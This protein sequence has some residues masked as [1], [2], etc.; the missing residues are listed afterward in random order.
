MCEGKK[1]G[2]RYVAAVYVDTNSST[3]GR[4]EGKRSNDLLAKQTGDKKM[5]SPV[6]AVGEVGGLETIV[7]G[8]P[9]ST[10][11]W[12]KVIDLIVHLT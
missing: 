6:R 12:I 9:L 8:F 5:L 10:S 3:R 2:T 1:A 11:I 7:G 4:T